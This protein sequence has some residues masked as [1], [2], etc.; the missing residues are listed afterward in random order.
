MELKA[1]IRL[2]RHQRL[3]EAFSTSSS[4]SAFA[5]HTLRPLAGF[6][7]SCVDNGGTPFLKKQLR[8][9]ADTRFYPYDATFVNEDVY[10]PTHP[11]SLSTLSVSSPNA[12]E[13]G[14]K[15]GKSAAIVKAEK[16]NMSHLELLHYLFDL[17][18]MGRDQTNIKRRI[19]QAKLPSLKTFDEFDYAY[20][21]CITKR[22]V[23]AWLSF[24][25]LE[26]RENIILM[27]PPGVGKT[28]IAIALCYETIKSGY[29]AVV[30]TM[31][32]MVDEL[33]LAAA[34][35]TLLQL[36]TKLG[37][38]DLIAIDE[39]GYLP[40]NNHAANLFFQLIN[41]LYEFRSIIITS[42]RLFNEWGTTFNDNV[43]ASAILDRLLHHS[44]NITMV[45]DSF[46]LKHLK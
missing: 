10:N 37:K 24:V 21:H 27:G 23:N 4:T 2:V 28:H 34:E 36:F 7:T 32:D 25:W 3:T 26:Q 16:E 5:F 20:Q 11:P 39:M 31:N 42:N 40:L 1:L 38:N 9:G 35:G 45:G 19:K 44:Q 46:R 15:P 43:I 13:R 30:F 17:E 29:K 12:S 41:H 14:V 22:M 18:C 8:K 33:I 6:D